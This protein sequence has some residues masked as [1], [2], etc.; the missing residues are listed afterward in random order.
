MP[1]ASG[2]PFGDLP[3]T[4]RMRRLPHSTESVPTISEVR[5]GDALSADRDVMRR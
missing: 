1:W 4:L 3:I 5:V 2:P